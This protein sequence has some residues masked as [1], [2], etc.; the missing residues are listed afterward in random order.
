MARTADILHSGSNINWGK[1]F[2]WVGIIFGIIFVLALIAG[3]I[4]VNI[5]AGASGGNIVAENNPLSKLISK[6]KQRL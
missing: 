1:I 6:I 3:I 2:K 5:E 4:L